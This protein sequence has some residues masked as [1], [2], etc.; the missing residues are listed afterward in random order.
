MTTMLPHA[1]SSDIALT[2]LADEAVEQVRRWLVE[3]REIPVDAAAA[4]LAGVLSDPNG[5]AFAVGF[6]DEVVR[7]EDLRIAARALR[8]LQ[9]IIPAFLPWSL[10]AAIWL[11]GLVAPIVPGIVVPIARRALRQMVRHLV[12]DAREHKLGAGIR[13][14]TA[15]ADGSIRLNINLLGEAILGRQE[16]VRRLAETRRLLSRPDVDYVSIKVSSSVPPH[17]AWSF[18]E[19][20]EQAVEALEPLYRVALEAPSPKF[21]NLDMEEYKDLDV[22]I[23]VFTSLLERPEFR[24]LEAGIVL[25]AYL[26]D[27][28]AA[29]I[30]LQ[31]WAAARVAAGGAPIKVRVVKGA[32]LPMERVDAE[33]HGWP[34]ATWHSKLETDASY[35]A[36]LDYA[37]QPERIRNLRIGV[38]GHNLFDLALAWLLAQRRGTTEGM[39]VEMLLGMAT[40]QAEVIRRDVGSLLL[41]TP[42]VNPSE[43]DVAIAYLVRRLE[44]SAST[45]NFMSAI[46][47]LDDDPALFERERDRFLGSL[48]AVPTEVP[49]PHR[50]QD[51]TAEPAAGPRDPFVNTPDTD[52]SIAVNRQWGA[53]IRARI[54]GSTL[55]DDTVAANT[56]NSESELETVI[57]RGVEAGARWREL[58]VQERTAI[59]HRAGDE[60]ERRR[61]QL[62]EVM[63]SEAGK[64]LDQGDPEVSEAIDFAHYY[65]EQGRML[66]Q[67]DGAVFRPARLTVV[68]PP[69]NFPVAIPAGSTLAALA[70]GSPVIIKPA[71]QARRSGAVMVEALWAAGVPKDVLQYVQLDGRELGRQLVAHEAVER[72]ILTGGYE[73]A[74][75]FRSFRQDLPLLAETSGKNAIIVTPSADLDLAAKD[76]AYSAFGHAGQKCS[77]ASLV[78][79]VGSV[80]TSRRF[81]EQLVDAVT[82]LRVG[83]PQEEAA[84][85]GPIIGPAEGKLLRGLTTLEPGQR[86]LVP[87]IK[88]DETGTLWRP[89]IRE[90]VKPGSEYHLTEYFGPILG[91]MTA[92]TLEQAIGYVN[93]IDYG[94]TSGLHSLDQQEVQTWLRSIEAG[95]L[96][97]NR[98]I[99]GAIVQRQPF[100]GWKK[101]VVGPGTKAGGPNYLTGLGSWTD[102][103]P[104]AAA[105]NDAITA[106]ALEA[107]AALDV[108]PTERDWL[109]AALATDVQAWAAEFGQVRDVTGLTAEQNAFRY[110]SLP[111]TVR[112]EGSAAQLLRVLAAAART[113]AT[114]T[115]SA[116]D[117]LPA[118]LLQ[119]ARDWGMA[120]VAHEG[121]A[122]TQ[123]VRELAEA[124]ARIRLIDGD[125]AALA[126]LVGGSPALTVYAGEVVSAGR[127][128]LLAF[129]REQAVSISAH[130]FGTPRR[131]EVPPL[132]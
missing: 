13:K 93:A 105:A 29:M 77:A 25:Q 49:A 43:F 73:T 120:A 123:Q 124:G 75:L 117:V 99:T 86:W 129:L 85:V 51:R 14:L 47:H 110:A 128:E 78:V 95:N 112:A 1:P 21:I 60:L 48:A 28:L 35:E 34:L 97:V 41:Y 118:P 10:R 92:D 100:G 36:V 104:T 32:N 127:I 67:V 71:R 111:V 42:V 15:G 20:V 17:S 23:A 109:A 65:A 68:T 83:L 103:A 131:Y 24:Q 52:P 130:R 132:V 30:R 102:A 18:D 38:A 6:V 37:L 44:E 3:S 125:A 45:E 56:L 88:L 8:R 62:L 122:W 107:A 39:E 96:Y 63:G 79:L 4:R 53:G 81:R 61:A 94:L 31:E 9:R 91:I 2:E 72:V 22:T 69:W 82:S 66:G 114:V 27:A 16:A 80:A 54:P 58:G 126:A 84:Q 106:R 108:E 74:E 87:P 70:S 59:L 98:G 40:A 57:A 26:P 33:V 12:I 101:S 11:G 5:L 116:P 115:V 113:G 76:V 64:L 55:G 119:L 121:E 19:A 89:G 90:G 46:F 50:V 7:P